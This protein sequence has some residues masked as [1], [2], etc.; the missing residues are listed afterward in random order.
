MKKWLLIIGILVIG[1]ITLSTVIYMNAID[2]LKLAEEK[3]VKVVKEETSIST[4]D[5]FNIYNGEESYYVIQG[6]NGKGTRLIA[7]IPEEKGKI[8]VKKASDGIKRQEAIQVVSGE[9]SSDPIISVKLGMEKGIPLWEVHTRT[10]KN[11]LNYY[12]IEFE[13]GKWLKKIENL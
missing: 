1:F 2:P 10:D 8:V 4:I 7:W 5:D 13:T 12:L 3:A 6:R 9:I 11:L